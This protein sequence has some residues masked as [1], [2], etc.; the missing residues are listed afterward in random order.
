MDMF[1][2]DMNTDL[3]NRKT[4]GQHLERNMVIVCTAEVLR[5]CLHKSYISMEQINLLIFDEAHHAKK[6]HPY[7]SIIKDFYL[8]QPRVAILPK[9]FGMTAS[10]VDAKVDVKKAAAELETLLHSE[11]ATTADASLLEFT[12][13]G[14]EEKV[15]KYA[16]LGPEFDT[17][18]LQQMM[19]KL[20]T[21]KVFKKPLTFARQATKE[22]GAW[23]ADQVWLFC[24]NDE[25]MKKLQASNEREYHAKKVAPPLE[26]L[27]K[28]RTQLE[29]A[30]AVVKGHT[31]D[32]P[33]YPGQLSVASSNLSSKVVELISI[34]KERFERPTDDKCIVFIQKRYTARALARLFSNPEIG[35]PHLKVGTLVCNSPLSSPFPRLIYDD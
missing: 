5:Q 34:L 2:G 35:T 1:C 6:G 33:D 11:I 27:E 22:L 12:N 9:I 17:P 4:W 19:D 23:C 24:L 21:N 13:T 15:V 32:P 31:F 8:Q 18:L 14:L 29:E 20:K 3:W 28:S 10:P 30:Q 7:A 16:T 25:E 26:V